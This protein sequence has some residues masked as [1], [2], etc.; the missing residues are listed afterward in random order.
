MLSSRNL[1]MLV[2]GRS[3]LCSKSALELSIAKSEASIGH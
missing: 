2:A 3:V 1:T